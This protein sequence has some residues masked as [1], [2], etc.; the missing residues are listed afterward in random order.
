MTISQQI[1]FS[2]CNKDARWDTKRLLC[3][4]CSLHGSTLFLLP[5]WSSKGGKNVFIFLW[6]VDTFVILVILVQILTLEGTALLAVIIEDM[7]ISAP[8][9]TA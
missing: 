7:M 9:A 8:F 4:R 3:W 5:F 2:I 6:M 1:K